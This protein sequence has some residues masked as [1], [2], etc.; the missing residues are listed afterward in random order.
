MAI[1]ILNALICGFAY[2]EEFTFEWPANTE[3]DM[4]HY[5]LYVNDVLVESIPHPQTQ[6]TVDLSGDWTAY[7]TAV[8][9]SGNE[10]LPS[11]TQDSLKPSKPG[12]FKKL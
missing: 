3:P 6:V 1:G 10:S 9:T 8:D 4:D 7:L 2:A 11:N 5:N 12:W